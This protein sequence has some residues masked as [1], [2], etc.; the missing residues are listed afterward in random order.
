MAGVQVDL[1][2]DEARI[3]SRLDNTQVFEV[4]REEGYDVE[5]T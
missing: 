5:L 1:D 2:A 3:A 4:T